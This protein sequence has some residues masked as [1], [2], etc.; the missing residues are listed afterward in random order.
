MDVVFSIEKSRYVSKGL[1]DRHNLAVMRINPYE[2]NH[3]LKLRT[4]T[5]NQQ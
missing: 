3:P 4:L 1:I 5:L 2:P